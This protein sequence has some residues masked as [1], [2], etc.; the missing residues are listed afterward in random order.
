LFIPN[1]IY[2]ITFTILEWLHVFINDKYCKFIYDWF[3]IMDKKYGNKIYGYV[4][5]PSHVHILIKITDRSPAPPTLI[6]NA[7]RFMAYQIVKEFKKDGFF[8]ILN[9]FKQNARVVDKAHY[10]VFIGRYDSMIIQG[11]KFFL[12]KLNYIHNNP[13]QEKWQLANKPEE[14]KHSSASNYILGEGVYPVT[15]MDF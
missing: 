11:R 3:S 14:Y 4:I 9:C 1:E 13:C 10:K 5:M 6:M 15:L 7:K 8:K 12:E 2:F